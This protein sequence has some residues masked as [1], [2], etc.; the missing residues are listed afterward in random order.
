MGQDDPKSSFEDLDAR[1]KSARQRSEPRSSRPSDTKPLGIAMRIS[2]EL[3][4]G[5]F[6]G[7]AMGYLLDRWLGTLP[8]LTIVFFFIGA[9]AGIRNVMRAAEEIN[10]QAEEQ[11]KGGGQE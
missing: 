7:G 9:A 5:L 1:L 8:W 3:V 10:R 4:A 6:V 11:D 2:V